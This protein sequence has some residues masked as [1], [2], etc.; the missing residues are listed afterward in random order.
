[1][2]KFPQL[3]QPNQHAAQKFRTCT[4]LLHLIKYPLPIDKYFFHLQFLVQR[5]FDYFQPNQ[6]FEV[7]RTRAQPFSF[8]NNKVILFLNAKSSFLSL[9]QIRDWKNFSFEICTIST[10]EEG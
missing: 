6:N 8:T 3:E 4:K 7:T 2:I 5:S 1:M 9:Q 10:I